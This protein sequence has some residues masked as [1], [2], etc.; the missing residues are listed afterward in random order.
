MKGIALD[1]LSDIQQA[2]LAHFR[3]DLF[4]NGVDACP[5]CI[6]GQISDYICL[7]CGCEVDENGHETRG[8][9]SGI[10]TGGFHTRY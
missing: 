10:L 3:P 6:K 5:R 2:Q 7:N 4:H 1:Y 9:Q 8:S